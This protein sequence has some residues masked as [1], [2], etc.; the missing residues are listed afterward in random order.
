MGGTIGSIYFVRIG[1]D[2]HAYIQF[3]DGKSG[4]RLPTGSGNISSAY[5]S[6]IS[7]YWIP[8]RQLRKY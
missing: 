3:G 8:L 2:D 1:K 6:G 5:R 7:G 4:A